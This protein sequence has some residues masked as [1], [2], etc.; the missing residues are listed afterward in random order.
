MKRQKNGLWKLTDSE[1][2]YLCC[3]AG[4]AEQKYRMIGLHALEKEAGRWRHEVY[5]TLDDNGF[6]DKVKN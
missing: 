2:N 4:E 6:Y 3:L 5:K 1:M